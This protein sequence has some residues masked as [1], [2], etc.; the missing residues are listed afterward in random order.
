MLIDADIPL[1]DTALEDMPL[2]DM[3]II[4]A[5]AESGAAITPAITTSASNRERIR[6]Y[7]T[8]LV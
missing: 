2:E 1:A 5:T 3:A 7:L 6:E 8:E 4:A